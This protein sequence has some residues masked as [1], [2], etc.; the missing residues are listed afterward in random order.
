MELRPKLK[1]A[2]GRL[3]LRNKRAEVASAVCWRAEGAR[4]SRPSHPNHASRHVLRLST[5]FNR[6]RGS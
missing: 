2:A 6:R 5:V 1:Q 4:K 3:L